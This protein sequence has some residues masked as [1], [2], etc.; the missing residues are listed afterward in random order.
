MQNEI[1]ERLSNVEE[2]VGDLAG[3]QNT[4]E[5]KCEDCRD[6]QDER[7]DR[8]NATTS[9]LKDGQKTLVGWHIKNIEEIQEAKHGSAVTTW[10]AAGAII[11]ALA[12]AAAAILKYAG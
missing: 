3:R 4:L 5:T 8:F 1:E 7:M 11:A 10:K 12:G 9:E 2:K 6:M